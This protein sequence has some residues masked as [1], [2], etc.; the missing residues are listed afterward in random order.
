M[1]IA[2]A[3]AAES[4]AESGTAPDNVLEDSVCDSHANVSCRQ[5]ENAVCSDKTNL[6]ANTINNDT[7]VTACCNTTAREHNS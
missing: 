1:Q 6:T 7:Q 3:T 2:G 5:S 4:A